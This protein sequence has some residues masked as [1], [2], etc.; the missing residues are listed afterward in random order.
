MQ[1]GFSQ[2]IDQ[3]DEVMRQVVQLRETGLHV[4][5]FGEFTQLVVSR[6]TVQTVTHLPEKI[7]VHDHILRMTNEEMEQTQTTKFTPADTRALRRAFLLKEHNKDILKK[8]EHEEEILNCY[9]ISE[10]PNFLAYKGYISKFYSQEFAPF[11]SDIAFKIP[12]DYLKRHAYIS[13]GS[14][15]GKSELVKQL[16]YRVMQSGSSA[17][18]LDP[19]AKLANEIAHW[20]E[21]KDDPERLVYFNPY[22]MGDGLECVP[23]I[24]PLAGLR[25]H[26]EL[27]KTVEGILSG[28]TA[29]VGDAQDLTNRMRTILKPCL[30]TFAYHEKETNL[31]DLLDFLGDE[32]SAEYWKNHAKKVLRNKAMLGTIDDLDKKEYRQT[33]GS[34]VDRIRYLLSSQ[35]L[36]SCLVGE[37]S[38][39]LKKAMNSGKVIVFN[40]DIG[41]KTGGAFGRL[42]VSSLA[43]LAR[44]RKGDD[45]GEKKPVFLFLDEAD[46]FM[47][48]A[49]EMIYKETRKYGLYLILVQQIAGYGLSYDT[50][51]A[52]TGNSLLR[53]A[54]STGAS[55]P[56][57]KIMSDMVK[58]STT[59]L[60]SLEPLSFWVKYSNSDAKKFKLGH[61]LLNSKNSMNSEEWHNVLL[62][63][64]SL[65]YRDYSHNLRSNHNEEDSVKIKEF[66]PHDYS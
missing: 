14:G 44:Q 26:V 51:N 22:A 47:T 49:I 58:V 41:D 2:L 25:N 38:I 42:I 63:Q 1:V 34:I 21:F 61:D 18:I 46:R 31:Y 40:L 6:K 15:H 13:A 29:V 52:I 27:D 60:D 24:N 7:A 56:C 35:A 45:S 65:Y 39:D 28:I 64:K 12:L 59:D 5:S 36:D 3:E 30:Y 8:Q 57:A 23:V 19:H 54:G 9:P 55:V 11:F 37:S 20:K 62:K 32:E 50:M 4:L 53:F 17:I 33:R 48:G 43:T 16:V 10:K 66:K